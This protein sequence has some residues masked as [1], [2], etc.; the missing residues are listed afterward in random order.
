LIEKSVLRS[1]SRRFQHEIG[2]AL[3]KQSRRP[4]NQ[5]AIFGLDAKIERFTCR[6]RSCRHEDS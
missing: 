2:S 1:I 3:A 6:L 5:I 4:I